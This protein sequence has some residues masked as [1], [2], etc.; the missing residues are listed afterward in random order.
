[1]KLQLFSNKLYNYDIIDLLPYRVRIIY[2]ANKNMALHHSQCYFKNPKI[3]KMMC[4][5]FLK[6]DDNI[7]IYAQY[8]FTE[9]QIYLLSKKITYT[10]SKDGYD[11]FLQSHFQIYT[12]QEWNEI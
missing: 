8:E 9:L 7:K 11:H 4:T 10:C 1:M 2:D 3:E 5:D 12:I 6:M